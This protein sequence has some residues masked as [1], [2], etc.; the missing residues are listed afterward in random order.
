MSIVRISKDSIDF[1]QQVGDV[2]E[3]KTILRLSSG[4]KYENL[5]IQKKADAG[6]IKESLL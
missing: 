6:L 3:G 4:R 2:I 5:E 1:A